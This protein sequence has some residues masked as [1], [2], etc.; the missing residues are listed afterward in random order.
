MCATWPPSFG[1]F[2]S[3]IICNINR[4]SHD[5]YSSNLH[6]YISISCLYLCP[7]VVYVF[8]RVCL[9]ASGSVWLCV[10]M[11]TYNFVSASGPC[12]TIELQWFLLK[13]L[14]QNDCGY[15]SYFAGRNF[16]YFFLF[17]VD[18]DA[19]LTMDSKS[20][21]VLF[22]LFLYFFNTS[23]Q[24]FFCFPGY[25]YFISDLWRNSYCPS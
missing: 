9:C 2:D 6:S 25:F 12:S 8:V 18:I 3:E 20:A 14:S 5:F 23:D 10:S 7:S 11:Y 22:W 24:I 15:M 21:P 19:F 4:I 13:C 17:I 1:K 16:L